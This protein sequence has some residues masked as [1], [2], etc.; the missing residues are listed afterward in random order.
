MKNLKALL[1]TFL[2]LSAPSYAGSASDWVNSA[3]LTA[4]SKLQGANRAERHKA[5]GE[6]VDRY[7]AL[8]ELADFACARF[9]RN[10]S[11]DQKER[12]IAQFRDYLIVSYEGAAP[13]VEGLQWCVT[14]EVSEGKRVR[15]K[16]RAAG[17]GQQ[18]LAGDIEFVLIPAEGGW[19][20]FDIQ[21]GGQGVASNLRRI[22]ADTFASRDEPEDRLK[23]LDYAIARATAKLDNLPPPPP[24]PVEDLG[25][26]GA[27]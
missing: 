16:V 27:E 25:E 24:P 10:L 14:G 15:V 13:Y 7:I 11:P 6:L 2:L 23:A 17:G 12:F 18:G 22:L 5:A 9:C 3:G 21:F 1:V 8:P 26:I 4:V 20:I 19:R